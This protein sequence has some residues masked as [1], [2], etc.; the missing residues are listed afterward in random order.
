[1][2][3][4]VKMTGQF[5]KDVKQAKKRGKNIDKL[6][7]VVER[8]SNGEQLDDKHR[9]HE[10]SGLYRGVRECH[11]EPDWLLAYEIMEDIMVLV[12]NRTG[13]HADFF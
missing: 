10:L 8:L 12:L 2:T 6:L 9:D 13:S 11:I 3:Y 7:A 4:V 1:M 5:R